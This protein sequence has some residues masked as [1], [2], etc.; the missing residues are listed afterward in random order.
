MKRQKLRRDHKLPKGQHHKKI[1]NFCGAGRNG[2]A[3][4]H[5][6]EG[7]HS[8]IQVAQD[9]PTKYVSLSQNQSLYV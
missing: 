1:G 6:N 9:I 8:Y 7:N 2:A 5:Q 3:G 4:N